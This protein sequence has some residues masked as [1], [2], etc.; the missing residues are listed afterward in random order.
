MQMFSL[1]LFPIVPFLMLLVLFAWWT[2]VSVALYSL[3]PSGSRKNIT[4]PETG[5]TAAVDNA[6]VAVMDQLDGTSTSH[7][8]WFHFFGLLWSVQ[9]IEGIS[10]MTIAGS[11][12][13]WYWR[14]DKSELGHAPVLA[15]FFRCM[16]YHLGTVMFGG[17]IVAIV[18]FIRAVLAYLQ[19]KL[20]GDNN[21][22]MKVFLCILQCCFWCMEKILKFINKQAYIQ[23]A[24]K[25]TNFCRSAISALTLIF[26]N[27]ARVGM[28]AMAV[29]FVVTLG[30][31]MIMALVGLVSYEY[32]DSMDDVVNPIAPSLVAVALAYGVTHNV[33]G[34]YDYGTDTI[35]QCV[36]EDEDA[37]KGTGQYFAPPNVAKMLAKK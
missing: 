19:K 36:L 9:V 6:Q 14:D 23:C 5:T 28:L 1:V 15:A 3:S 12:C 4:L 7:L 22:A 24:M 35:M 10:L 37:N 13:A 30:K 31:I 16:R 27:A 29:T 34:I 11:F 17:L 26:K 18:Q 20:E 32:L 2:S 21:P 25:G 33:M 8:W